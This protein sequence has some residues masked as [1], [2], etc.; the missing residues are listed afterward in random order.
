MNAVPIGGNPSAPE[1]GA[2]LFV[3]V[4]RIKFCIL[5]LLFLSLQK[6]RQPGNRYPPLFGYLKFVV[7][8]N[9]ILSYLVRLYILLPTLT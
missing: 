8:V 4:D 9:C 3:F 6:I 5:P 2:E 1:F 7:S